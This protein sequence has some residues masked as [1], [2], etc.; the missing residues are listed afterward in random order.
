MKLTPFIIVILQTS[1]C[2]ALEDHPSSPTAFQRDM[3]ECVVAV[4]KD[5]LITQTD[6][7]NKI[8]REL[9]LV[10]IIP[11]QSFFSMKQRFL[12]ELIDE[13]ILLQR[14]RQKKIESAYEIVSAYAEKFINE[15]QA[16][17]PDEDSYYKH[18]EAHYGSL[19]EFKKMVL[20]WEERDYLI[21][22]AVAEN[23]SITDQ[24]INDYEESLKKEGQPVKRYRLSH[25][26]RKFPENAAENE[27][28]AI[29]QMMLDIL[30]RIQAGEDFSRMVR[31]YS[32][33]DATKRKGGDLGILEQGR[34]AKPLEDA[35]QKL[36]EGEISL[37]I[38]SEKGVHLIRLDDKIDARDLLFQ[39]KF[40]EARADMVRELKEKASIRILDQAER[41]TDD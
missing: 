24:E 9:Y 5:S 6:L 39:K 19:L 12:E 37:P 2:F 33:D 11:Q 32:E 41:K 30:I 38:R 10:G 40:R 3:M 4:V 27:K 7:E 25:L 16:M 18:I 22:V 36:Q 26:Y 15:V 21:N 8:R 29:E 20:K 31:K 14:A 17:F 13:E 28:Q 1:L 34:F 23:I 35:V